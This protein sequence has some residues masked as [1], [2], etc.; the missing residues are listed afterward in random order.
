MRWRLHHELIIIIIQCLWA[1]VGPPSKREDD[2]VY[3]GRE[4]TWVQLNWL[5]P[6]V[7]VPAPN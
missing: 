2:V 5:L 6:V 1:A 3:L 7:L 4:H